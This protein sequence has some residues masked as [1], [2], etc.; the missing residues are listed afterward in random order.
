MKTPI[1][2]GVVT[3]GMPYCHV[4]VQV[5][6]VM[7]AVIIILAMYYSIIALVTTHL[8][9]TRDQRNNIWWA[10]CIT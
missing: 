9:V 1:S 10:T 3:T 5:Q 4:P 2:A 6:N 7:T 8:D